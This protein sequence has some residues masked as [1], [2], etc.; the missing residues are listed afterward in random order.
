MGV[1]SPSKDEL[2]YQQAEYAEGCDESRESAGSNHVRSRDAEAVAVP[3][4]GH[5][6]R[7]N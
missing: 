1:G 5:R 2:K 6:V 3:R 4:S 7:L